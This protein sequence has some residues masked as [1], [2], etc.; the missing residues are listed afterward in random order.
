MNA[1]F[2]MVLFSYYSP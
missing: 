2:L 1:F